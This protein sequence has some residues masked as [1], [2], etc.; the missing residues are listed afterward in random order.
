M[1]RQAIAVLI[2]ATALAACKKKEE[3]AP[4]EAPPAPAAAA[5]PAP[6][7]AP[8][9]PAAEQTDEQRALAKKQA[10]LDYSVMEDKYINDPRAQWAETAK[11][12]SVFG[13]EGGKEPS[14]SNLAKNAAGPSDSQE[15]TSG[16]YDRGFDTLELTYAKPVNATEVRIVVPYA[17]GAAAIS[18]VELHDADGK[19]QTAWSGISDVKKDERGNRTWFIRTFDK[20]AYK[21]NGVKITFANNLEHD[22]KKVESVQLVGD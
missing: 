18:K 15:W 22:Y 2:C 8:A 5:V 4:V 20:T 19:W 17:Q 11:A 16:G 7:P 1:K 13:D 9:A 12:S 6:A 10:L 3:A 14:S 21:A